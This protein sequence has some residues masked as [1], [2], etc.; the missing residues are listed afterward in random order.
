[1][2]PVDVDLIMGIPISP[3]DVEDNL[4]WHFTKNG[5]GV[6]L[7]S[8]KTARWASWEAA[9][10]QAWLGW[11]PAASLE[12]MFEQSNREEGSIRGPLTWLR[13]ILAAS[14]CGVFREFGCFVS[15]VFGFLVVASSLLGGCCLS[16]S[17]YVS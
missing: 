3:A 15:G 8:P 12:W 14:L 5:L 13:R 1:M 6:E 11:I 17:Q 7:G 10:P 16:C 2:L 4:I 9:K